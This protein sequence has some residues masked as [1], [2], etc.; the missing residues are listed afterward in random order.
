MWACCSTKQKEKFP[1]SSGGRSLDIT[2]RASSAA[3]EH[4]NIALLGNAA[5]HVIFVSEVDIGA[6]C[7]SF[8]VSLGAVKSGEHHEVQRLPQAWRH[9]ELNSCPK[10]EWSTQICS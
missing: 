7:W 2:I 8:Q 9:G 3:P 5:T 1:Q 6:D 10:K 4:T